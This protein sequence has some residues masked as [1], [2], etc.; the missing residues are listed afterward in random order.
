MAASRL[1]V[2][3]RPNNPM[4]YACVSCQLSFVARTA[5]EFG[6]CNSSV[7][8]AST[9]ERPGLLRE[10]PIPRMITSLDSVPVMMNPPSRMLSPVNTWARVERLVMLVAG[11]GGGGNGGISRVK[12][13]F[14]VVPHVHT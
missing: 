7:G 3:G 8:S 11:G 10:G 13:W 9:P 2:G 14:A 1:F 12:F 5:L 6:P 4:S